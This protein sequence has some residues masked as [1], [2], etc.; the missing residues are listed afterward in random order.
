MGPHPQPYVIPQFIPSQPLTTARFVHP[1]PPNGTTEPHLTYLQG[2]PLI[3]HQRQA[4]RHGVIPQPTNNNPHTTSSST[5]AADPR[6]GTTRSPTERYTRSNEVGHQT[7]KHGPLESD[8]TPAPNLCNLDPQ[9]SGFGRKG[10]PKQDIGLLEDLRTPEATLVEPIQGYRTP[11][12]VE[13]GRN[14][15]I[16]RNSTPSMGII[17]EDPL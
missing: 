16:P 6:P 5:V 15:E 3:S 17:Q 1:H 13:N 7:W 11:R 8:S 4:G 2:Q 10:T 12:R 14:T 9:G